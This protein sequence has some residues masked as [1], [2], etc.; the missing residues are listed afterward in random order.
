M[1]DTLSLIAAKYKKRVKKIGTKAFKLTRQLN[2]EKTS[3]ADLKLLL[4]MHV[5]PAVF[6]A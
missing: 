1:N 5:L 2:W 4:L 3:V 6:E